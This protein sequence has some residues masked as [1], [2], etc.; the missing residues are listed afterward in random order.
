MILEL[1]GIYAAYKVAD[2]YNKRK[3]NEAYWNYRSNKFRNRDTEDLI[4]ELKYRIKKM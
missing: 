2:K 1:I 3:E 4:R